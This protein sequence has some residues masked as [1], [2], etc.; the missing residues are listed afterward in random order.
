MAEGWWYHA[1]VEAGGR[2]FVNNPQRDGVSAFGGHSLAKYYE[3]STI[4][5]GPFMDGNV[6]AGTNNG[7]YQFDVWAKNIGYTDQSYR[8]DASKAGEH[9][10]TLGWDQIPHVYSTSAQTIYNGVGTNSLTV[11]AGIGTSIFNAINAVAGTNNQWPCIANSTT[12]SN[13][14]NTTNNPTRTL[15]SVGQANAIQRILN[16]DS[17]GTEIGIRRDTASADYRYTPTDAWDIRANYL[18]TRRTGT[19]VD[20]V[21]FSPGTSGVAAQVPKPVADTTQNYGASGEYAGTSLWGQKFNFKVAYNGSTYKDDNSFYTVQ[22]PFCDAADATAGYGTCAR[23]GSPSNPLALMSLWPDNQA[24]AFTGTLGAELPWKSRYMGTVSYTMM[25]QNEAFLPFT[26]NPTVFTSNTIPPAITTG[27]PPTVP[28][29]S[30]NGSINTLL[31]NNVVTTQ[32]TPD[33]KSKA[34]YRYYNF[35]NSTPELTFNDWVVTDSTLASVVS[36]SY[37]PVSSLSISYTKQ[38]AGEE[39]TWRPN[40]QWNLGVAYGYERYDWTRADATATNENSGRAYVDWKPTGNVT[41]RASWLYGQRH[42]DGYDYLANVGTWQWP[43]GG[44]TRYNIAYRQFYLD[45]RERSKGQFSVA[46]EITPGLTLT[47]TAGLQN[48]NYMI[49]PTQEGLTYNHAWRGGAELAWVVNPDTTFLFG[50]M[51]ERRDQQ[52]RSGTPGAF[53]NTEIQ[54]FVNTFMAAANYAVIPDRLDLR[55]SYTLSLSNDRQPLVSSTGA[56][57]SYPD[58]NT[59]WQRFDA[60]AKYK[61]DPTLVHQFG[62]KGNV[63]AKVRYAWER[64]S[65]TNWQNDVMQTYMF[66]TS[67]STAYMTWMAFDNPN[68]NV[69]LIAASLGFQW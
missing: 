59:K 53:N 26:L 24:N 67:T 13:P 36:G 5:P 23:T 12:A 18:N 22:N 9:Y 43:T 46:W 31:I 39:L 58:V 16:A 2:F 20:G 8:L 33:L 29:S 56:I 44:N 30:L 25:R 57:T 65:V 50:Y 60:T 32:I 51:N 7:L 41:A 15:L 21:V 3:Y 63:F 55:L 34:T 19:Q 37:V 6:S 28:Y 4:K 52:I 66:N 62:W 54:D 38:N 69:H 64:T 48:D 27:A 68:Y 42:Y 11:P 40:R 14:C 61:I 35:D 1:Y 10:L 49:D 45:N 17:H 47:P